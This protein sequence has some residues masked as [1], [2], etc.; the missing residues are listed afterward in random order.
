MY[1]RLYL[2]KSK[3]HFKCFTLP[4]VTCGQSGHQHFLYGCQIESSFNW[5]SYRLNISFYETAVVG[6]EASQVGTE[7]SQGG[8]CGFIR[9]AHSPNTHAASNPHLGW[10]QWTG[11]PTWDKCTH[12]SAVQTEFKKQDTM[13]RVFTEEIF[14]PTAF[15]WP[16]WLWGW[17]ESDAAAA[18][19]YFC[20]HRYDMCLKL[21]KD[22]DRVMGTFCWSG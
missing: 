5:E 11:L 20:C 1:H 18:T 22:N 10:D 4:L 12:L 14:S 15:R 16:R 6:T 2:Y 7:A 8:R 9:E 19:L 21:N 17:Q 13:Q 3:V